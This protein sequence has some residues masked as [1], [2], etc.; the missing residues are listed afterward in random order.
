LKSTPVPCTSADAVGG[1]WINERML[2]EAI[3]RTVD[4]VK[5]G[6]ATHGSARPI[7]SETHARFDDYVEGGRPSLPLSRSGHG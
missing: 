3:D 4:A 1:S 5:E 6:P 7:R 2:A